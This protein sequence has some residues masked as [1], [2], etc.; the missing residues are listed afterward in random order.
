MIGINDVEE[1]NIRYLFLKVL[2]RAL[3]DFKNGSANQKQEVVEWL[4]TDDFNEVCALADLLPEKV[5]KTFYR[6]N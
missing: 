2:E 4:G 3:S 1:T 5:I 6:E